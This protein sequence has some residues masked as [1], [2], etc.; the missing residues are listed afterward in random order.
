MKKFALMLSFVFL[1]M[2][3]IQAQVIIENPESPLNPKAGRLIQLKKLMHITDEEG[4]FFLEGP[5]EIKVSNSGFIFLQE[6][7]QLLMFSP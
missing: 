7:K 1:V 4:K 3:D 6:Y 2:I 5:I